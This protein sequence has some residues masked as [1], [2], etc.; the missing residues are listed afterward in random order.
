MT[1]KNS[2][3]AARRLP[4]RL[5]LL[6]AT[7]GLAL[8]AA[9][10]RAAIEEGYQ[11]GGAP[12]P[13]TWYE[14]ASPASIRADREYV[15]GMRPHHAGAL[16]MAKEYLADPQASSPVLKALAVA[17]IRNQSFEIGLLDEVTR[18]LDR[19]PTVLNLG[20]TRLV[21]QPSATEGM[22]Q[23]ERFQ[24]S[25]IPGP[26]AALANPGAPVTARDVQFAK[27]MTIHHQAALEMARAY[28]A[29][30]DARNGFLGLMNVD[31]ITDQTQEIALMQRV[32][33]AFPGDAD[34]VQVDASMIHGMEGMQHGGGHGA[35]AGH[36]GMEMPRPEAAPAA[37]PPAA[38]RTQ[39]PT[40]GVPAARR[41]QPL[42]RGHG[43]ALAQDEHAHHH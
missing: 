7:T 25:P 15:A 21:L 22:G 4:L 26:A 1:T 17:V 27:G 18:N 12:V 8:A 14:L 24:R 41:A 39:R 16:T 35:H 9:P 10:A 3:R 19:S 29:N 28:H 40:P 20:F 43:G 37:E 42:H 38:P 2:N 5:A 32:I 30:P 34:A 11:P 33:A 36:G 6:A 13:T 31:I 23:M